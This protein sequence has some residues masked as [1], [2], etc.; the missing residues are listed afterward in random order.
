MLENLDGI[1]WAG[2]RHAYGSAEDTPGLL[3]QAASADEGAAD[4]AV[5]E[6]YGSIFHQGSVYPATVAAV[7]FLARIAA[8]A[9]HGRDGVVWMLGMLADERHAYDAD[10]GRV[11]AA[12]AGQRPVL[13]GADT[14]VREAAAYA[15]VRAGAGAGSLRARWAV[16][17]DPA[18]RAS[19]ALA[20]AEV[21][22]AA[23]L[24]EAAV[25]GEP[26]V[27]VAAAVGLLRAG[28]E[29]PAGTGAGLVAASEGGARL[30]YAWER[31]GT[32]V[33]EA[34]GVLPVPGAVALLEGMLRSGD[35]R[36]RVRRWG[37]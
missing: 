5:S 4:S 26:G 13:A 17:T 24:N 3:R 6:L 35:A 23:E 14:R 21:D 8:S 18:V 31:G 27:R 22:P 37:R 9:P 20:W 16:E 1:D 29:W 12:V 32:W 19:L 33:D 2:L 11:R 7:P 15:A 36:T 10:F 34:V 25:H 30:E 28:R